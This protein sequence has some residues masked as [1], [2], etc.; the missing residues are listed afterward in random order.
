M[1]SDR[2]AYLGGDQ[3]DLFLPY[4]TDLSFRDQRELIE[5]PFFSFANSKR[6]KP[7]F[8]PLSR[9]L[10][11]GLCFRQPRLRHGDD[12]GRRYPDLMRQHPQRHSPLKQ[13]HAL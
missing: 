13:H 6:K 4:L 12:L 9:W 2:R 7:I 1:S 11:L 5:R 8:L 3:F 10:N